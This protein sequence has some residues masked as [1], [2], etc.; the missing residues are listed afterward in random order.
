MKPQTAPQPAGGKAGG[1][2]LKPAYLVVGKLR[3]PHGVHGEMQMEVLTDFPE[4]L[5]PGS[6]VYAS[7]DYRALHLRSVRQHGSLL[8]VAF[9]EY[10][11]PETVGELRNQ[12]LFVRTD[13]RPP[14]PSG[15]YY[16]HEL[17]GLQ[18]LDEEGKAIGI[19]SEIMVTGANDVYVVQPESGAEIL[20]PAI[21]ETIREIDLIAGEMRVHLLPGLLA[22][23][24]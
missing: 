14:L 18:V 8:R 19:L 1:G 16:H 6:V 7:P 3:R 10:S 24:D 17:I 4:R 5:T 15:E 2:P 22:Q 12:L 9:E 21:E 13:D 23:E 20:I 11:T